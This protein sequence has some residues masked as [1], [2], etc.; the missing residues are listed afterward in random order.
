V[1]YPYT[2]MNLQDGA[3]AKI[4]D[5]KRSCSMFGI[6]SLVTLTSTEKSRLSLSRQLHQIH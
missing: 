3:S 4:K 1:F 2:A 6:N 5:I